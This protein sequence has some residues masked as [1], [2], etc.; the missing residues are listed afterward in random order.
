[1]G[2]VAVTEQAII[3]E[4]HSHGLIVPSRQ[5]RGEQGDTQAAGAYVAYPKKGLHDWIGS[6][7]INS[8]YP[9]MPQI[10]MVKIFQLISEIMTNLKVKPR[11]I[12]LWIC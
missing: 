5:R 2:A 12:T 9:C 11:M 7:D 4:A 3:N 8:L 1:M 6:M 10:K